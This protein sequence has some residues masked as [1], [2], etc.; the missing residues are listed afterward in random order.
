MGFCLM[1][2]ARLAVITP[3]YAGDHQRCL[4]LCESLD[5]MATVDFTH[6]ILV[7]DHDRALFAP[8]ESPQRHVIPDSI[9]LPTWLKPMMRPFSGERRIWWSAI[10]PIWPMSGWHV[11]QIRKMLIARHIDEDV[12]VMADSDS[13]FIRPFGIDAFVRDGLVRLYARQN[14]ITRDPAYT[15]HGMWVRQAASVLDLP[16]LALPAT[17]YINNLVSWR[18]D[19]ALAILA[20][21][22][23]SSGRD[24]A[25][26]LG[27]SRTFS[28]YQIYGVFVDGITGGAGHF[29]DPE[30]LSLTYWS[31][32]ALTADSL[33]TFVDRLSTQQIAICVQSFTGTSTD[34]LRAYLAGRP[35]DR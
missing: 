6:Y 10:P 11:Q 15:K 18:R 25:A 5:R 21:I 34:L 13:V 31:G 28:E 4:L 30:P 12:M 3:S 23:Q 32:D 14:G 2:A 20:R 9:L 29:A 16:A 27:R 24:F 26:T 17:D 35:S 33:R 7:A 1:T 8:L 22:E 19:H